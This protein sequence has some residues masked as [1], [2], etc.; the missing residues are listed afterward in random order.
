M[1]YQKVIPLASIPVL[2]GGYH[3]RDNLQQFFK[4]DEPFHEGLKV[5]YMNFNKQLLRPWFVE[6]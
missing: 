2:V 1:K 5:P 4:K 6:V 3:N